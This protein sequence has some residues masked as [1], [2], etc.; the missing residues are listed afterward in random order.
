MKKEIKP[1]CKKSSFTKPL[2]KLTLECV[3]AINNRLIKKVD[4][5]LKGGLMSI[6]FSDIY[7]CKMEEHVVIPANPIFYKR[8]VDGTYIQRKKS[9]KQIN[10]F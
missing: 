9:M 8:Y 7:V 2:S 1:F 4:G 10:S 3:F 5:C 6:V